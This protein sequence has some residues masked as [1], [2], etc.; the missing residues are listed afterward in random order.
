MQAK[1]DGEDNVLHAAPCISESIELYRLRRF[2][3]SPNER[4]RLDEKELLRVYKG[5]QRQVLSTKR[6]YLVQQSVC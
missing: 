2:R 4:A 3:V 1:I 5:K 6:S